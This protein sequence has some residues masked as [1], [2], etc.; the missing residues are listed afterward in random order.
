MAQITVKNAA[1]VDTPVELPNANGRSAATASR[2]VV[3]AT[4]D[5]AALTA[6]A[7]KLDALVTSAQDTVTAS[8]ISAAS[9]PLPA[10]A[11]TAAKQPALGTAGVPSADVI[12][13]Q[14]VDR[15][16]AASNI[17]A[18]D[19]GSTNAAGQSGV[20]IHTGT[21]TATGV[22]SVSI[23]GAASATVTVLGT[24]VATMW[25]QI[26]Y[27]GTNWVD[28]P[29]IAQRG[30]AALFLAGGVGI[31]GRGVF[32]YDVAGAVATRLRCT[33]FTSGSAAVQFVLSNNAHNQQRVVV[34]APNGSGNFQPI[35]VNNGG[36]VGVAVT[37]GLGAVEV[38]TVAALGSGATFTQTPGA[39]MGQQYSST[40]FSTYMAQFYSDQAGTAYIESSYDNS[41][42]WVV[43]ATAPLVANTLLR[44]ECP[45][46]SQYIRVRVVNGATAQGALRVYRT[47]RA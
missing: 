41:T 24:F 21:P 4:E 37:T 47:T 15:R 3:L 34:G 45:V 7:T 8:P 27:D 44:L 38:V 18:V 12:T 33:A 32:T 31:T 13:T 1:N 25:P 35:A 28:V 22:A 5:L 46:I 40:S 29:G 2:P 23:N 10:G 14:V 19:A 39:L 17:T 9:L 6:L 36:G 43:E 26:T 11:A 20:L 30:L 42:N 16:P